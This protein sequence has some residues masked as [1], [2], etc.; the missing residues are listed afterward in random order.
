MTFPKHFAQERSYS[1]GFA[2]ILLNTTFP[3]MTHIAFQWHLK[4][5]G[6]KH[7]LVRTYRC[8]QMNGDPTLLHI[9]LRGIS[10]HCLH[11][12]SHHCIVPYRFLPD[13]N[14]LKDTIQSIEAMTDP[15]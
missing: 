13:S 12:S 15:L 6:D 9:F 5:P 3:T 8:R 1:I 11:L 10:I 14:V 4:I 2:E 7:N